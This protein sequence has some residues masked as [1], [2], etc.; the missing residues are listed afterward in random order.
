MIIETWTFDRDFLPES[1]SA[2][3]DRDRAAIE[4]PL[5]RNI[6]NHELI[7]DDKVMPDT[8]DIGWFTD[9]DEFGVKIETRRRSRRRRELR[10]ATASSPHQGSCGVTWTC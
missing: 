6:R 7:D 9:I 4:R 2:L 5:L 1:I 10:P 8:F 3:P